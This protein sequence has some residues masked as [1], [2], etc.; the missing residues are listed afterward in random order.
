[1][2][3]SGLDART[4]LTLLGIFVLFFLV[5]GGVLEWDRRKR[6]RQVTRSRRQPPAGSLS[7][8]D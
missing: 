5:P 1:V 7:G 2:A 6:Q 8:E 4:W 3:E